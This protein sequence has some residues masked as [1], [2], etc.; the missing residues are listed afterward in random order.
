MRSKK[1]LALLALLLLLGC[2]AA[3]TDA[4]R[5]EDNNFGFDV[6]AFP[7]ADLDV[8]LDTRLADADGAVDAAVDGALDGPV[9]VPADAPGPADAFFEDGFTRPD[10]RADTPPDEPPDTTVTLEGTLG[11]FSWVLEAQSTVLTL[12]QDNIFISY[13]VHNICNHPVSVRVDHFSDFLP[14]GI[15]RD[16]EDWIFLPGCPG[17]GVFYEETFNPGDGVRR[18][19][20]WRADQHQAMLDACGVT[21]DVT[22]QYTIVG[23]G[24]SE[25]PMFGGERSALYV[26]TQPIPIILNN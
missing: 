19:W 18:G 24:L 9:D 2:D 10:V 1:T 22:S 8:D 23:Y 7:D 17:T 21:F 25:V 3:S 13:E 14:V 16:G 4:G 5:A 20:V 15:Q 26:L 11:C 12:K 6:A